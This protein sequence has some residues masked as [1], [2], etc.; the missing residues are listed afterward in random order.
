MT[1]VVSFISYF[2]SIKFEFERVKEFGKRSF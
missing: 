1:K 2:C